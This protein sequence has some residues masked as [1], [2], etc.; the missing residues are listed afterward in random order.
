M[1]VNFFIFY[2]ELPIIPATLI[3]DSGPLDWW[4]KEADASLLVG[5]YK[6]G[7][8]RYNM[9][10]MDP[11]LCFLSRCGPPDGKAVMAEIS[12]EVYEEYIFN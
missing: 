3:V 1:Q 11:T 5:T 12:S 2:S 7:Y 10:R 8:E 6:H 9:M 4:D